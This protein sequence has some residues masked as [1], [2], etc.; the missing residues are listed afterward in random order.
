[1]K[2]HTVRALLLTL[3]VILISSGAGNAPAADLASTANISLYPKPYKMSDIVLRD[4]SGRTVNLRDY[5][6]KVVLLHFWSINCPACRMEEPVLESLKRALGPAGLE[7][8]GVNLV[9]NPRDVIHHA[10]QF[11]LPFPVLYDGGRGFALKIVTMAGKQTAFLLNPAQEAI[12]EVPGFPTTYI[13]DRGGKAVGYSVGPARWNNRAALA[14]IRN[15]LGGS[16]RTESEPQR[17][18]RYAFKRNLF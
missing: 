11:R 2:Y 12:L 16:R 17:S 10:V 15:L 7:I 6:G 18:A 13:I 5:R 3:S 4:A 9:D 1:M 14:F 8:L